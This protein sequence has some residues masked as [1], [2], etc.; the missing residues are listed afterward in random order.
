MKKLWKKFKLF[1][2]HLWYGKNAFYLILGDNFFKK[3]DV[4]T[5]GKGHLIMLSNS[6]K[7]SNYYEYVVKKI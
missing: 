2:F 4:I 1:L 7:V 3:K 6:K 5:Y